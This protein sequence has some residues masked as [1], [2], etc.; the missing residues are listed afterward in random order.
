[1]DLIEELRKVKTNKNATNGKVVFI[2]NID[3][4]RIALNNGYRVIDIWRLMHD[5]GEIKVKY[6]QF[7]IYVRQFIKGSDK[8]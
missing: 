7:S 8:C 2:K 1:M 6:N 3:Q 5:R 4:I